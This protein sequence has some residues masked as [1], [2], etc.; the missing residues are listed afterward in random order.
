MVA[1][2]IVG[3][4]FSPSTKIWLLIA[5]VVGP[6]LLSGASGLDASPADKKEPVQADDVHV[7]GQCAS[8]R[9]AMGKDK[10]IKVRLTPSKKDPGHL[11]IEFEWS[12]H[13]HGKFDIDAGPKSRLALKTIPTDGEG[14]GRVVMECE[15]VEF[16]FDY[17]K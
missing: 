8:I 11:I 14:D 2:A 13:E 4:N 6:V 3:G 10:L 5:L 7:T 16:Q 17:D 9:C 15:S 12:S 1:R